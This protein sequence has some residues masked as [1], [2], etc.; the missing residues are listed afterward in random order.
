MNLKLSL[1]N[2]IL[3]LLSLS[4][5]IAGVDLFDTLKEK[6]RAVVAEENERLFYMGYERTAI[7]FTSLMSIRPDSGETL[8]KQTQ[9]LLCPLITDMPREDIY[10][11]DTVRIVV[12]GDSF[13]WGYA[14][15]NRNELFWRQLEQSLRSKGYDVRIDAVGFS[16]ANSYEE[17]RWLT[18]YDV[19]SDLKP[20]IVLFGFV[21][22][23]G[24]PKELNRLLENDD[25]QAVMESLNCVDLSAMGADNGSG[26]DLTEILFKP[27][28]S[29]FINP[30]LRRIIKNSDPD[31]FY[32]GTS[33]VSLLHG[34]S[35]DYYVKNFIEPLDKNASKA[36]YKTLVMSLPNSP[37]DWLTGLLSERV[38]PEYNKCKSVRFL[39]C[40]DDLKNDFASSEHKNNYRVNIADD[41]PG[42][43][44]HY[45]YT[46]YLENILVREY[47]DILGKKQSDNLNGNDIFIN[48]WLPFGISPKALSV[49][50]DT[51]VYSITYPSE[52]ASENN[53]YT[54][55]GHS[56]SPYFLTLPLGK[57]HIRI[58]FSH[59]VDLSRVELSG[60]GLMETE[61]YYERI[62]D[63]LGYDDHTVIPFGAKEPDAFVWTDEAPDRVTGLF[64]SAEISGGAASELTL[65]ISAA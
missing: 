14:C 25:K 63:K 57:Q 52:T 2:L 39:N 50:Q 56:V 27:F 15:L 10:T 9:A 26:S 21:C 61:L 4:L 65:T 13:I 34:K 41:H 7:D 8:S 20:D 43:A 48:D 47:G 35:L 29:G 24:K 6:K 62:N 11:D 33:L 1:R 45:F 31:Y 37:N 30:I 64:I 46:Q 53:Q 54:S 12:I 36:P 42:S 17:L 40:L 28:T 44:I 5:V 19:I 23:D 51:S 22:D 60:D 18:E 58:N 38:E 55:H 3:M 32:D 16:G 59:P 49:G